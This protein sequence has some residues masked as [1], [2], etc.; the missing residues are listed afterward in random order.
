MVIIFLALVGFFVID[1]FY[2]AAIINYALQCQLITFLVNV[3]VKRICDSCYA[4]DQAIKVHK[5]IVICIVPIVVCTCVCMGILGF[6]GYPS[7]LYHR[8]ILK[9]PVKLSRKE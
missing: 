9:I 3:T 2:I 4:V 5:F 1:L 6:Q 7:I 8:L